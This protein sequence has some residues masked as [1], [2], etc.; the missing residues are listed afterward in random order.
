MCTIYGSKPKDG[1]NQCGL[2]M[3][4]CASAT[5]THLGEGFSPVSHPSPLTPHYTHPTYVCSA[6]QRLA[7]RLCSLGA[8]GA[9]LPN[10]S[11][12]FAI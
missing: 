1:D 10:P 11:F 8:I 2:L 9:S 6:R 4:I 12:V 3:A 5:R 7:G